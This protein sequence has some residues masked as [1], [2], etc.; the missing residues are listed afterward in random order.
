MRE[1]NRNLF[2]V[3]KAIETNNY[4]SHYHALRVNVINR[5]EV[6]VIRQSDLVSF[7]PMFICEPVGGNGAQY[8]CPKNDIDLYNEQN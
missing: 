6:K 4:D 2:F 5:G 3:V 8:V 7:R 1:L